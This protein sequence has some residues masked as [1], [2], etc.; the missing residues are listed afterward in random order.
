MIRPGTSVNNTNNLSK[1]TQALGEHMK[2]PQVTLPTLEEFLIKN[3]WEGAIAILNLEK[4]SGRTDTLMWIA[5]CYFH[6]GEYK[7]AVG[8]YDDLISKIKT[9]KQLHLYKAICLFGLCSFEEAKTEATKAPE[10]PLK[11]RLLYQISQKLKDDS[12]IMT[13][14]HRLDNNIPGQ[15]CVAA[16]HYLR[17]HYDDCIDIYK[18]LL[19]ENKKLNAVNIY[20][21]LCYYKQEYFEIALEGVNQYLQEY[22]DSIFAANLKA[23]C[24]FETID[25]KEALDEF[26]KLEKIFEGESLQNNFDLIRHNTAVFKNGENAL[27]VF[28]PLMDLYP[29]AKM[30]LIIYNISVGDYE[31]AY[32]LIKDLECLSPKQYILKAVVLTL[33][34][35][36]KNSNEI[37]NQALDIYKLIGTSASECDTV[38]GRQ[39]TSCFMFLKK[40][41]DDV[42]LYLNTIKEYMSDDDEFNWNFGLALAVTGKFK[43]AEEALLQIKNDKYKA[44]YVFISWLAKCFIINGK[45]ELAW[46]L[47]LDMDT[48]NETLSLLKLIGN[49]CYRLEQFYYSIKAFD[50][51]ERLDNN[52]CIASKSGAAAGVFKLL[53]LGKESQEHFEEVYQILKNSIP[54]ANIDQIIRVFDSFLAEN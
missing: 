35:Q 17:G 33:Y 21:S 48:S 47:Y 34:G 29:E 40:Q 49:E 19:L 27:K 1:L 6:L 39:C 11:I 10:C 28:P 23:C 30:N 36:K 18:K 20:L 52:E 44:D 41:F 50:I 24:L 8:F 25:G 3:D 16:V 15:M 45:P 53:L 32:R 14:H 54:N 31:N 13:L 38:A 51:L 7:K 9:D 37:I 12:T 5:Y 2:K 42:I 4:S 46:N 26:R 43:E 22:P